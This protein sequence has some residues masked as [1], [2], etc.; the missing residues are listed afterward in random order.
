M[1]RTVLTPEQ[2]NISIKLP[3]N[4]IGRQVAVIAF[5]ID[6]TVEVASDTDKTLTHFASE[7]ILAKDWLSPSE[8]I[9]WQSL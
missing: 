3:E 7:K 8:D 4:F 2:Q 5:T 1:V 9:A 6:D